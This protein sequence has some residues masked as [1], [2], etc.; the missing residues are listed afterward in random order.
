M[1]PGF[2]LTKTHM[3]S[4][5]DAI[6]MMLLVCVKFNSCSVLRDK[7]LYILSLYGSILNIIVRTIID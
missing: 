1:I 6:G 4:L 3:F 2:P 5:S 7:Q